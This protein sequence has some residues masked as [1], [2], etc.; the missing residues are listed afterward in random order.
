MSKSVDKPS[1]AI[2]PQRD[3]WLTDLDFADDVALLA[4][5]ESVCQEMTTN[6]AVHSAMVGLHI[7]QEKSRV[8]RVNSTTTQPQ[9]IRIV[10]LIV[11]MVFNGTSAQRGY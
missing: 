11:C 10:C 4:E 9:P 5:K 6:L 2:K 8:M 7:N 1:I 3:E